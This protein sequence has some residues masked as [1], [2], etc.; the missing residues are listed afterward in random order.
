VCL[1]V[2][3]CALSSFQIDAN[4]KTTKQFKCDGLEKSIFIIEVILIMSFHSELRER[5]ISNLLTH[6]RPTDL[7]RRGMRPIMHL[8][9]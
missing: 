4:K 3:T 7:F 8:L 2:R 1:G 9:M 5:A 6:S